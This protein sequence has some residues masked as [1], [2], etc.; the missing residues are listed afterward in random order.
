MSSGLATAPPSQLMNSS[1]PS[2][3]LD[4]GYARSSTATAGDS[5]LQRLQRLASRS[6]D[7]VGILQ[8]AWEPLP[9]KFPEQRNTAICIEQTARALSTGL[10]PP[11]WTKVAVVDGAA[12][13]FAVEDER[14]VTM[15]PA[16]RQRRLAEFSFA[17]SQRSLSQPLP[18]C[19][20]ALPR[21]RQF[22]LL[23]R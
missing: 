19:S 5:D 6:N 9:H 18:A 8:S 15:E 1:F 11:P 21:R 12:V 16:Q 7:R 14:T 2:F 23:S 22:G 4:E 13:N 10:W 17:A 3:E 20:I